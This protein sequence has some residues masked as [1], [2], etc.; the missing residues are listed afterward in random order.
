MKD[1]RIGTCSWKYDSWRGIVYPEK[2][3]FDFLEEYAHHFDTV[4]IDQWFW[5]L[6][7][8]DKVALP[9]ETDVKHYAGAVPESFRFTV[10]APNA[11]TLS[12]HYQ[13]DKTAPLAANPHFL[14]L[15]LYHDF[16][17]RLEP[18][19][20]K[21]ALVM[22]QFEYLNRKKIASQA[23]FLEKLEPFLAGRPKAVPLAIECRNPKFLDGTYF[24]LLGEYDVHHVF[25]Q[26]YYMPPVW[27]IESEFGD[28]LT[29]TS[30]IR[31]MGSDRKGME[32]KS[33]D[34]WS[35]II[36]PKDAELE[37]IAA[38]V[39]RLRKRKKTVYVNINNHYEGS[40]PRTAEKVRALLKAEFK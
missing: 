23:E 14:S 13:K 40:A 28:L 33:N 30:V 27:E 39:R 29:D 19:A 10:K 20:G 34:D 5:S 12:H 3:A 7:P 35:L 15:G 25:C 17:E 31:L 37:K 9:K 8:G 24:K 16:L 36:E 21:T 38:M 11:V 2:G 26:G 1:V 6:F 32:L 18:M 22:L 4:E